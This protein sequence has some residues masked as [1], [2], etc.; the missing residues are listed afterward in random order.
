[1]SLTH[2]SAMISILIKKIGLFPYFW[3]VQI[4]EHLICVTCW[5]CP[6]TLKN[7][8]SK[9]ETD[10]YYA[11]HYI[12]CTKQTRMNITLSC[13]LLCSL[14]RCL[15]VSTRSSRDTWY[16]KILTISNILQHCHF[17]VQTQS[18][19]SSKKRSIVP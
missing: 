4:S 6:D 13:T 9:T 1:M 12:H 15:F 3:C 11:L 16:F 10:D 14:L 5:S 8:V 19:H 7:S 2:L 18:K 17:S